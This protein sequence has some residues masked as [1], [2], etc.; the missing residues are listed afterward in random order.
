MGVS[1]LLKLL[2]KLQHEVKLDKYHG[3]TVAVDASGWLYRGLR[4]FE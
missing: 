3:R 1:G 2:S 4:C